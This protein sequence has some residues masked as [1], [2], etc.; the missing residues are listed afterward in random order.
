MRNIVSVIAAATISA[1]VR[2][3]YNYN[4]IN[5]NIIKK[6]THIND[7]KTTPYYKFD[8]RKKRRKTTATKTT[9][10]FYKEKIVRALIMSHD[11]SEVS[12]LEAY[13]KHGRI[14]GATA[15]Q[16]IKKK[17]GVNKSRSALEQKNK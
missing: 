11:L 16:E 12:V 14:N 15:A 7:N 4:N 6:T 1:V 13:K 3:T 5:K 9:T 10:N 2:E 8:W 17:N